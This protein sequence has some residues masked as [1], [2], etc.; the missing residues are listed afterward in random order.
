MAYA[1]VS[2][3]TEQGGEVLN[4]EDDAFLKFGDS[5]DVTIE[6]DTSATPDELAIQAAANNTNILIGSASLSFDLELYGSGSTVIW[7]ASANTLDLNGAD[8]NVQDDDFVA[9]GDSNDVTMTWATTGTDTFTVGA[10]ANNAPMAVGTA[11]KSFDITLYGSGTEVTWDASANT[12]TMMDDALLAFGDADD[13][14]IDWDTSGT[15]QLK[16]TSLATNSQIS[17]G[18]AGNQTDVVLYGSGASSNVTWDA[19]ANL[20]DINESDVQIIDSTSTFRLYYRAAPIAT[21]V[22]PGAIQMYT[23]TTGTFMAIN[24]TDTTWVSV[25]FS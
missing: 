4:I 8:I 21:R 6:W 24:S 14:T 11:A 5:D 3:N 1:N 16:I 7:D 12:L 18:A 10:A 13:V 22:G 15:D 23:N 19:S 25:Q 17:F 2:I 20:L 9:F